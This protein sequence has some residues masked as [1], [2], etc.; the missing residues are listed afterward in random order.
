[1]NTRPKPTMI[2]KNSNSLCSKKL[3]KRKVL[4]GHISKEKQ[5]VQSKNQSIKNLRIRETILIYCMVLKMSIPKK[6]KIKLENR[7]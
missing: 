6:Q 7:K 4:S 1:M 5:V 2:G 3:S